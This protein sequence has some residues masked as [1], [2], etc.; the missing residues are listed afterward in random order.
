MAYQTLIL[1]VYRDI[2]N[3]QLSDSHLGFRENTFISNAR[4]V[5]LEQPSSMT[6]MCRVVSRG[7]LGSPASDF[8]ALEVFAGK[9]PHF[10]HLSVGKLQ[11][12]AQWLRMGM[13][14]PE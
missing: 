1:H 3:I 9:R 11:L 13:V 14:G 10:A 7:K 8:G 4:S 6:C 12:S 2:G 5:V